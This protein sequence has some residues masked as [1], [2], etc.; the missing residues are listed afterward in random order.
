MNFKQILLLIFT[1]ITMGFILMSLYSDLAE[2]DLNFLSDHN[3]ETGFVGKVID[4]DTVVI[5]GESVRL[6]GIDS[7][8]KGEDCFNEAKEKMEELVLNKDVEM[9]RDG[10]NKDQYGRLLKYLFV[11]IN[12]ERVN[13]Q[14][15]MVE[16]GLAI[17]RFYDSRKYKEEIILA[18]K[19]ARKNKVGCKWVG[20]EINSPL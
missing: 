17:A 4:G 20:L 9:E 14:L 19:T 12:G 10:D 13:V 5:N 3:I 8:E 2:D 1:A 18:E 6:L 15:K 16:D 7:N 11:D